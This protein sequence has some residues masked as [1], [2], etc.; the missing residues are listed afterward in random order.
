M[1]GLLYFTIIIIIG[2]VTYSKNKAIDAEHR[3]NLRI[4]N[5]NLYYDHNMCPRDLTTNKKMLYYANEAGDKILSDL[6]GRYSVNLSKNDRVH[7]F[8]KKKADKNCDEFAVCIEKDNIYK[9]KDEDYIKG[10]RY[11][12]LD[13]GKLYVK[14]TY[15]YT[16]FWVDVET[17]KAVRLLEMKRHMRN[18]NSI[19]KQ[20]LDD[21]NNYLEETGNINYFIPSSEYR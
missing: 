7:E 2:L 1:L 16:T 9:Y 6:N 15:N 17:K 4:K 21:Y 13:D 20:R 14:R 19:Q 12:G 8:K 5:T 18:M 10:K 3:T 11:I